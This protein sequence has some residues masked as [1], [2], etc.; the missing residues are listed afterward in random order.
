[1]F[2]VRSYSYFFSF[3]RLYAQHDIYSS[4]SNTGNY[5]LWEYGDRCTKVIYEIQKQPPEV[6]FN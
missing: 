5:A 3:E 4:Y 1:M 2:P 6:F